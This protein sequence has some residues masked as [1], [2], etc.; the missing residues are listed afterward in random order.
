M[1]I[2][3]FL[4]AWLRS[5]RHVGA[6]APS[7]IQLARALAAQIEPGDDIRVLELGPGTGTTTGA[8]LKR[9][10]KPSNL[11]I[12]ERDPR[13]C[14]ELRLRFPGVRLIEGDARRINHLVPANEDSALDWVVSCLPMLALGPAA[15]LAILRGVL[16]LIQEKGQLLQFTYG[17][18]IPFHPQVIARLPMRAERVAMVWRN[19]PPATVWRFVPLA[20][21]GEGKATAD[22]MTTA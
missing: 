9:G 10:I 14:H 19:I 20:C 15:Q 21:P 5:P 12:L 7:S 13:F 1:G 16:P 6:V 17:P 8:L 22:L 11:M 4:S 3:L 18:S 2:G